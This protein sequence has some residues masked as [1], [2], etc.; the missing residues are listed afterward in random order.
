MALRAAV[1]QFARDHRSGSAELALEACR[2]LET[3]PP[4]GAGPAPTTDAVAALARRLAQAVAAAQPSLAAVLNVCNRWSFAVEKGSSAVFAARQLAREL[5]RAQKASALWASGWVRQNTTVFT[6]SASSTVLA[7][8]LEARRQG[9]EF[10]V[11]CAESRPLGEGRRL[12]VRLAQK[13]VPVE[14]FTDAALFS[15]LHSAD[16]V[17]TGCDALQ[18]G[19][20]VNKVGTAAL[21]HLAGRL[22]IPCY[23]VADSFKLLPRALARWWDLREGKAAEVW[24]AAPAGVAVHND[25]FERIPL[26]LCSAVALETGVWSPQ[27]ISGFLRPAEVSRAFSAPRAQNFSPRI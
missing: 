3:F 18:A 19:F 1:N 10:R 2:I 7:A 24:R 13:G 17:L 16:L 20:F 25:Y 11:F 23:V 21:L 8:L 5:R 14:L 27:E 12:A 22:R 4:Q 9:R 15:A 6:Y 26:R